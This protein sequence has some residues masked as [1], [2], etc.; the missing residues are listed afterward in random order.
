MTSAH[1]LSNLRMRVGYR[2]FKL[3]TM[4]PVPTFEIQDW[5]LTQFKILE[6]RC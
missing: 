3:R 5:V 4:I 6:S 2:A 1:V